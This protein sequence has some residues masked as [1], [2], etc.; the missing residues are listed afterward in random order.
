MV[1]AG[2]ARHVGDLAT[3]RFKHHI[4]LT[5][6]SESREQSGN[7]ERTRTDKMENEPAGIKQD[8]DVDQ[9]HRPAAVLQEAL[10]ER[11]TKGTLKVSLE[12]AF[13]I[14]GA[15]GAENPGRGRAR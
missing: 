15:G 14:V 4:E 10:A 5:K 1:I 9:L 12:G 3:D 6:R 11:E 7:V 2:I 8:L 13:E